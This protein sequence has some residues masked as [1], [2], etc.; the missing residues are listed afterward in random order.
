MR[1]SLLIIPLIGFLLALQYWK[2]RDYIYQ[3][4][5]DFTYQN[6]TITSKNTIDSLLKKLSTVKYKKLDKAYMNYTKSDVKKYRSMLANET[7]YEVKNEQIYQK[8]VGNFRI[9]DFMAKDQYYKKCLF[10]K[11]TT[12]YWL[13]NKKL[14]YSIL[15]LQKELIKKNYDPN[16][17]YIVNGHRHPKYNEQKGGAGRS[18]HIK[19]EA[20]DLIIQDINLDGSYTKADKDIVLEIVDKMVIGNRGGVGRYPKTRT[21]HID[22][23]GK[24]ARWDSF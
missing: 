3:I 5:Y 14:L 12:Q 13:I 16:A 24:R 8:I 7:Y 6:P 22:V 19:G 2:S 20:A 10:E 4:Y 17:F 11:N 1:F 23:R 15:H 9:K 18:R 21:V